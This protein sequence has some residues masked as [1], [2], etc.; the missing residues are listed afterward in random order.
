MEN[1]SGFGLIATVRASRT[2]PLGVPLTNFADD[3]DPLDIP[4][5]QIADSAMGLNGDL[6]SWSTANPIQVTLNLVPNSIDDIEM[7]ILFE[8]NRVGRGKIGA[9]DVITMTLLYPSGNFVTLNQGIITDGSPSSAVSSAG[10]LKSKSYSFM[11]EG[12]TGA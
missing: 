4:G 6:I 3:S 7:S 10:R 8:A 5:L 11:F 1:I 9:R 2:F 12:R